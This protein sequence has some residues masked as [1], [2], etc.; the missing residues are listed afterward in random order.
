M[1]KAHPHFQ[2]RPDPLQCTAW[3]QKSPVSVQNCVRLAAPGVLNPCHFTRG[4][5]RGEA[6]LSLKALGSLGGGKRQEVA[7]AKPPKSWLRKQIQDGKWRSRNGNLLKPLIIKL[8]HK[9]WPVALESLLRASKADFK[10]RSQLTLWKENT[11]TPY[12]EVHSCLA[13]TWSPYTHAH[14]HTQDLLAECKQMEQLKRI[15]S[16]KLV[17]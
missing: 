12:P 4:I 16:L 6:L 3:Q 13:H 7:K 15:F 5:R 14:I 9:V 8:L 10:P 2:N 17:F 1:S 11:P